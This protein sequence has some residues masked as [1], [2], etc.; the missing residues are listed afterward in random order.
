M[1]SERLNK[2]YFHDCPLAKKLNIR[3]H[4]IHTHTHTQPHTHKRTPTAQYSNS[5]I[6]LVLSLSYQCC[7]QC[8][9]LSTL[10]AVSKF[11]VVLP[12]FPILLIYA[13]G[14]VNIRSP[15]CLING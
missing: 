6:S 2:P 1:Q 9:L 11:V 13:D 10:D 12:M 7:C 3:K 5:K 8:T 4:I 15:I 14:T